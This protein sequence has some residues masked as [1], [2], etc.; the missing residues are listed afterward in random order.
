MLL[1]LFEKIIIIIDEDIKNNLKIINV[2]DYAQFFAPEIND[3]NN[4][5]TE[6]N[7]KR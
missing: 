7:E 5:D 4:Q 2:G 1:L 3:Q 6:F